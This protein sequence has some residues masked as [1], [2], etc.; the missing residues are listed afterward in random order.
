MSRSLAVGN[1]LN[2]FRDHANIFFRENK[3]I[4]LQ[5]I[6]TVFFFAVGIWFLKHEKTEL[7][8]VKSAISASAWQYVLAG[9]CITG[10][11][12]LLQGLMYVSSFA[13]LGKR[14]SLADSSV[15]FIKRNF[16]SVFLPAGGISSLAFYS[17]TIEQKGIKR[18]QIYFASS[19]YAFVGFLSVVIVAIPA[20]F[21]SMA[22]GTTGSGEW[23]ALF[24][25]LFLVLV[26]FLLYRSLMG[27]GWLYR[28][29][30][31]WIP[32]SEVFLND[33]QAN[34]I[35][36]W[37]FGVTV[38]ISVLIEFCGIAHLYIAMLALGYEPSL[39]AAVSGYIISVIFLMISPFLR[40]LGAVE[41]SMSFILVRFG[42]TNV[43][44]ISITFLYRFF[45]F[46]TPLLI[47]ALSFLRKVN[48]L[49]L[50]VLPAIFIL[51]LGILNIFSVLTPAIAGRLTLL[52]DF[53]PVE[54]I[55]ASNMLVLVAGF[56]LLVTAAF[57]LKGLRTAWWF[58][59]LLSLVSLTGHITKAIDFEEASIALLVILSLVLTRKEYYIR[60]NPRLR[61]VGLQTSLLFAV[62]IFAYGIIGFYFLD[63]KHFNIDFSLTQSIRF[64]LQ[65][66]FLIGS[67]GLT[68]LDPFARYFLYSLNI[69]GIFS[70]TFLVYT[71]VKS[72]KPQKN[73]SDEE[74]AEANNLMR[75][76]GRS[77]LDYFKSYQDKFVFFSQSRNA[78]ISYRISGN[79]AV[80]LEDPVATDNEEMRKCIVEFDNY[81]YQNSLKNIFYRVSE[82]SLEIYHQ[83]RKK[84]LFLGQE[85]IVDLSSF[86]LSGSAKKSLRNA[87]NKVTELGYKARIYSPPIWDGILQKIKAVSD[88]WLE[89]TGRSEIVF[90]QGQFLWDELKQQVLITVENDEERIVAFMNIVPDNVPE[91]ATFDLIR[92]T[93]DAPGGV[94]DYIMIELFNYLTQNNYRFVNIGFAPMSGI[95]DPHTFPERSMR[96]AYERLRS[97][98]HY[99]GLR[100]YKSKFDPV[101]YNKYLIYQHDF[102]LLQI[103]VILANVIKP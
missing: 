103:P 32:A 15:L 30:I 85:G 27:K 16:I 50:R 84:D 91:E 40:G 3:K 66:F 101:W 10:L 9:L 17:D 31:R 44:A 25:V 1:L 42:F 38:F 82:D 26:T 7:V 34:K 74:L 64:T 12:I 89:Y 55:H 33:L 92:K 54:V 39:Y 20:F 100:D 21:Y 95:D 86:S 29:I 67:R 65:N 49:L 80:V 60:T 24:T 99:K 47:G 87:I 41:V 51:G 52:K 23:Y 88:E 28:L 83:L 71:L 98:S 19:I 2:Y 5:F 76:Y 77:A 6:F 93:R 78:F 46:W 58:A 11:Y 43:E 36:A 90:S 37:R 18:S 62:V 79:Y 70:I 94:M 96:F 102:D 48:K 14:V 59:L 72:Y 68:A 69:S 57:M 61:N 73:V 53:L 22:E 45:E 56:F 4:I 97:F 35:S 75:L 81:T 13:A 8:K 63:E